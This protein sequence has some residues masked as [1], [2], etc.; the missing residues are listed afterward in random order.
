MNADVDVAIFDL[1]RRSVRPDVQLCEILYRR[2]LKRAD[3][4]PRLQ[5]PSLLVAIQFITLP[6]QQFLDRQ[7]KIGLVI[8]L[9]AFV[10]GFWGAASTLTPAAPLPIPD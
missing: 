3:P 7:L 4:V 10:Y 2:I 8:V 6:Q 9:L 1:D 5:R